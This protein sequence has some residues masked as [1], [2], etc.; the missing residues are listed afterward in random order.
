MKTYTKTSQ[1]ACMGRCQQPAAIIGNDHPSASRDSLP[2][3]DSLSYLGIVSGTFYVCLVFV[4]FGASADTHTSFWSPGK[5]THKLHPWDD[6]I[7]DQQQ[8]PCCFIR[9]T[10]PRTPVAC[11][12]NAISI[13]RPQALAPQEAHV[14]VPA[15]HHTSLM[16]LHEAHT[17]PTRALFCP[18]QQCTISKQREPRLSVLSYTYCCPCP[19]HYVI[20]VGLAVSKLLPGHPLSMDDLL[21]K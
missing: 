15:Y 5:Y 18:L 7:P 21:L 4:L 19:C 2:C 11:P 17:L 13:L 9:A 1:H 10:S 12:E 14:I 16:R 6:R 3:K 8:V 20:M